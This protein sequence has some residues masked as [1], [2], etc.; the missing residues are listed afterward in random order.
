MPNTVTVNR[1]DLERTLERLGRAGRYSG[2]TPGEAQAEDRLRSALENLKAPEPEPEGEPDLASVLGS[3]LA[4]ALTEV[5]FVTVGD[6][7]TATDEELLAVNGV[8]PAKV[9][10]IREAVS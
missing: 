10:R 2:K 1:E 4:A 3:E 6:V 5:G 8:G 9:R 7:A